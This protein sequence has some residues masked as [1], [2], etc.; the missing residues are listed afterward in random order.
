MTK[1]D[2][3]LELHALLDGELELARQV[4]LEARLRDDAVLR[5]AL[6]SLERDRDAL[7]TE[8]DYHR[9][10]AA[11]LA[12]LGAQPAP[13]AGSAARGA[14][15]APRRRAWLPAAFSAAIALVLGIGLGLL[16]WQDDRDE[17]LAREAIAS[18]VRATL[19]Q[20]LVDVASSDQHTVKPWLSARLDYSPPLPET[21]APGAV[22]LGGRVDYLEGHPVAA[23]VYRQRQHGIDAFVWPDNRAESALAVRSERG[24]NVVHWSRAG[25]THWV[26]SDLNR[27]ELVAFAQALDASAA[28]R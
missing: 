18:H 11:L 5:E 24:F 27:G 3:A 20:R 2:D 22:F 17:A 28:P 19:G 7:R 8:A 12:R 25:M 23:L 16:P 6:R 26:V 10:P 21:L 9:A 4:E 14:L 15:A 13:S 1:V